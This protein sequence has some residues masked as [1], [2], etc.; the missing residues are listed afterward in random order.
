MAEGRALKGTQ[1]VR[2]VPY[3]HCPACGKPSG[4]PYQT[5]E[6]CV[7]PYPR[8]GH[9]FTVESDTFPEAEKP[10]AEKDGD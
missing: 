3:F 1:I 5:G 2:R 9:S 7:C 8:C 6:V 10:E 4:E